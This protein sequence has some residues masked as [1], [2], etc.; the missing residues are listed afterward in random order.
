M[1]KL[2]LTLM[3]ALL[4]SAC[5]SQK[6]ADQD[7]DKTAIAPAKNEDGEWD[8]DVIDSQYDYFLN[9]IARPINMFT[10]TAL[11]SRNSMLVTQW[12]SYYYSGRYRNIIESPID[13]NPSENYGL[14]FEYKLYQVFGFVYW[15]YG[16]RLPGMSPGDIR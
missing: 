7:K 8:I 9:A 3:T 1:K 10:E 6:T 15:K 12:N 11:K 5:T 2:L 16:L 13:Y 4:L 14:R